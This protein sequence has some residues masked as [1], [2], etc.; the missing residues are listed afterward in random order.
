MPNIYN[1]MTQKIVMIGVIKVDSINQALINV[2]LVKKL[3]NV[4]SI[5]CDGST[6]LGENSII[7]P[8]PSVKRQ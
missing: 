1:A 4:A 5:R 8:I 2:Q 6:E 3:P 7:P